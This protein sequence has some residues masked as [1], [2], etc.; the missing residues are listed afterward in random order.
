MKTKTK[1]IGWAVLAG[2]LVGC[3]Q[4][5]GFLIKPVPLNQRLRETVVQ[6]DP[7]W[8]TAKIALV[9]VDG[10]IVNRRMGGLLWGTG[11]NPV[12]LFAEK[13]DKAQRDR[14]VKAVVVRI[15][16]PG[17]TVQASEAMYERVR[18]FRRDSGKPVLS[19]I[20]DVGASGGY[21]V[22]CAA[23]RI[24]CQPSSITGSIGVMVQT[25]SFAGTMR[26]LGISAEAINSG[27]LKDMGSPLKKLTDEERE[28]FQ[29]MVDEF[30]GRFVEVVAEG[31]K[32]LT[33]A[34]VRALADGRVY[35][36]RQ[37]L[38]LGLVDRLGGLQ[39]AVAEAKRAAGVKKAKVV[40]YHRPL[41]YRANVYSGTA[42][43]APTA[44]INLLNVQAGEMMFLR[45]P[46]F[47]YL[48]STGLPSG[49][50]SGRWR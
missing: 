38:E 10:L 6:A 34:K 17:G 8:V 36:G 26:M 42:A 35:T 19:C 41:G 50:G 43:P 7:G 31:R 13:L 32:E 23:E 2:L 27:R 29:G 18:R 16:S 24:I 28:V 44:Q 40:M 9:D 14:S 39:D 49:P 4:N 25:V 1:R 22:A 15:N 47:L 20:T 5:A 21:Y 37:A 12:P 3:G 30:Y 11:E 46:S 45:R 48:W 33:P